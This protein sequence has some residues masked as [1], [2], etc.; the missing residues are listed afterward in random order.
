[1]AMEVGVLEV[2]EEEELRWQEV[3]EEILGVVVLA[4]DGEEKVG[5]Q[6]IMEEILVKFVVGKLVVEGVE[7]D[8]LEDLKA[9]QEWNE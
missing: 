1:M 5:W 4:K 2:K 8:K 6:Q 3:V 9:K 7:V